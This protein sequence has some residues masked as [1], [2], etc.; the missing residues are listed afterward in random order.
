M[1]ELQHHL[2]GIMTACAAFLI[3]TA[4]PGPDTLAM[5]GTSTSVGR[6]DGLALALGV[7]S[8]SFF[9]SVLTMLGLTALSDRDLVARPPEGTLRA[10]I[11]FFARGLTVQMSNLRAA[12][13]WVAIIALVLSPGAPAW[14]GVAIV[15]GTFALSL[16][17]RASYAPAFST[18]PMI[19][20]YRRLR[21]GVQFVLGAVFG[22]AGLA[23]LGSRS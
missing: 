9:W 6:R 1:L 17:L 8:G 10:P 18:R 20:F 7:V 11:R 2:P 22:S 21:R 23:L 4:S 12:L 14:V 16:G 19:A 13:M 15:V 3:G 5:M